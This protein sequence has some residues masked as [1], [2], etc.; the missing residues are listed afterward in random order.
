MA[1]TKLIHLAPGF[2]NRQGVPAVLVGTVLAETARA[3]YLYGHGTL[4]GK[5]SG[6]C[7]RCGRKL[8]HPGSMVLGIGPE[9]LGSWG[10]RDVV[11]DNL[12]ED[13]IKSITKQIEEITVDTWV[14]RSCIKGWWDSDEE[15][16]VPAGHKM[17]NRRPA[18]EPARLARL[19]NDK[20]KITFPYRKEDVA[21]VRTLSGRR[22]NGQGK[23]W[24]ADLSLKNVE[25]LK[26]WGFKLD[27]GL[28]D[29]LKRNQLSVKSLPEINNIPGLNATL[30]P[31]Q[32]QG[33]AWYEAKNGRVLNA[34]DMGLGKTLQTL[35]WLQLRKDSALPALVICP[36]S[37]KINWAREA[38][39][40]TEL[41]PCLISGRDKKEFTV[42]PG[43]SRHDIY[44][45]NYDI[46]S[47]KT[48]CTA[49]GGKGRLFKGGPK[50]RACKGKGKI[51]HA[52][53]T[54]RELGIKTLVLDEWHKLKNRTADRTI[55]VTE[56]ARG[57]THVIGLSGT[58]IENRPMEL[59]HTLSLIDK[60]VVPNYWTFAQ[61]YCGA[62]HNGFGWDF[63]GASN[64]D[65]LH[66]LLTR[67]IMIRRRKADVLKDL[68]PKTRSFIPL[69][70]TNRRAYAKAET[71]FRRW[72]QDTK[73]EDAAEWAYNAEALAKITVL[74]KL[75]VEGKMKQVLQW[76]KDFLDSGKKLVVFA[77]HR[78]VIDRIMDEFKNV[79]VRVDGSV[80]GNKRQEA[81]DRFQHDDSV[82]LFVGNIK[83]A[84]VG[85]TLTA[86]SDVA[87]LELPWTP[88]ELDQA[89]DRCHRIG[90]TNA[91]NVYYLL[92]ADT[93]D[94]EM[95]ELLD[96]KRE[97]IESVMDG[98]AMDKNS[99]LS[100]LIDRY[101][102]GK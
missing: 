43:G 98:K 99:M 15:V 35:A 22:W 32:A 100:E 61:R 55:A 68:P 64:T 39:K 8:T 9:C 74:R 48:K 24:T 86:A 42:F 51:V 72:L 93:I 23:Y 14:P 50:C 91:V 25:N 17:L 60:T 34:D 4:E 49:C 26:E 44:I 56:L 76:I 83:A 69:E 89:E 36:A 38:L 13:D 16:E 31:Y 66:E 54:L 81:V 21:L 78:A 101:A 53:K 75:V 97:V 33:V 58:P 12:T 29:Y 65:E 79:A 11:I 87:F 37:L 52:H 90:Q 10:I 18:S 41:E 63:T 71:D 19:V 70:L 88:T 82:K 67:T 20:I 46:L 84:G 62:K 77:N 96:E 73:G 28:A 57:V 102:K 7:C 5:K 94:E 92:A 2:A 3:V 47:E 40:F 59:Y 27:Q 80:T 85:L 95:A 45:V 6:R 1:E 30:R